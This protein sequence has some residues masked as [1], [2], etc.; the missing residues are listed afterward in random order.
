[1]QLSLH[2]TASLTTLLSTCQELSSQT[3]Q[4]DSPGIVLIITLF[5][6]LAF[7]HFWINILGLDN[8]GLDFLG[9]ILP[10]EAG[11]VLIITLLDILFQL[12]FNTTTATTQ[13][14]KLM[15]AVATVL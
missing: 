4:V 13:F 14:F 3:F 11:T 10:L 2:Y 6:I 1:M 8:F 12:H 15:T 7:R 9:M 5:D